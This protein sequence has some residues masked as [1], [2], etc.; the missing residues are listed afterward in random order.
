TCIVDLEE[1]P[2]KSGGDAESL[3]QDALKASPNAEEAVLLQL[4]V[5]QIKRPSSTTT[6]VSLSAMQLL[7]VKERGDYLAALHDKDAKLLPVPL[8]KDA[9]GGNSCTLVVAAVSG[10]DAVGETNILKN[11]LRLRKVKNSPSRSGNL[12]R[13]VE[14]TKEQERK[15]VAAL[16]L[17]RS[18]AEKARYKRIIRKMIVVLADAQELMA[19]PEGANAKM[20]PVPCISNGKVYKR[21]QI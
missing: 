18:A 10:G 17:T 20:Y 1:K 13:F 21:G 9:V 11:V 6:D 4:V 8:F 15:C 19:K 7:F 2:V 5:K 14:F 3:L 16:A 12:T